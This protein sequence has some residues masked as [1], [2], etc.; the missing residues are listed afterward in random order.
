MIWR[1]IGWLGILIVFLVSL[2]G[3]L[4]TEDIIFKDENY[5]QQH[6][7]PFS[8]SLTFSAAI[9]WYLGKKVFPPTERKL[10]DQKTGQEVIFKDSH[11]FFFI[12]MEYWGIILIAGGILHQLFG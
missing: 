2:F 11:D 7:W 3:E 8:L 10:I 6:A 5:Y 1:G 9:V 4:L 12:R